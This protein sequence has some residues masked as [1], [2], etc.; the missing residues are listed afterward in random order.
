MNK[1]KLYWSLQIGGWL[2]FAVVQ[3]LGFLIL[4][5]IELTQFQIIFWVLEAGLFLVTTH[6]FRNFIIYKNWLSLNMAR[7]IPRV[8]T[9]VILLAL[10]VY[11]MRTFIAWPLGMFNPKI[12]LQFS[13]VLGLTSVYSLIFFLWAVLYFIYHYFESYNTSLKHQAA[14]NEIQLNNLR[15]QLNP[16]F[17]FN[18]LNSIR[19]LVDENPK[20]SK[21]SITQ[22]SSILRNSLVTDKKK[23][24]SFNE[25]LQVV[26]DYLG[27][28]TIRFEE[29]LKTSFEIHPDSNLYSIP[30]LM[31]QTLVENGVKH[32]ISKLKEGGEICLQTLIIDDELV[33]QIRNTGTYRN[34]TSK[35]K[36]SGL[37][38][39]N[40]KQRLELLFGDRAK[41]EITN[42]DNNVVLTQLNIPQYKYESTNN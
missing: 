8:I 9:S 7:L 40:T 18:A 21:K 6:L 20:K 19:A 13:N 32:G 4:G 3:I 41:I 27:L 33:I 30:P 14:I 26:K 12:A 34:N 16:H 24:T 10:L 31:L 38:L 17:I 22:L 39:K 25:E 28:E 42:E 2:L 35:K 5:G 23:L 36:R 37:G 11:L 1:L 15:S 29:R